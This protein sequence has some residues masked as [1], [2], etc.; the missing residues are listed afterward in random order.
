MRAKK[1]KEADLENRRKGFLLMGLTIACAFTL[2]AFE[3]ITPER[4]I[5]FI[6][7]MADTDIIEIDIIEPFRIERK[8][9]KKER[10]VN[11]DKIVVQEF[12]PEPM[13]DPLPDPDPDPMPDPILADSMLFGPEPVEIT[14]FVIVEE[15]PEFIGGEA[16]MMHW[17]ESNVHYPK[18]CIDGYVQGK[19]WV[20]FVVDT[21]G[22]IVDT[23]LLNSE[24]PALDREAKRVVEAMPR[25]KP[26]KQQGRKVKVYY[27]LP[28]HFKL[29]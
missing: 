19:V 13:P 10:I 2:T 9:Q 21:E 22:N 3:W 20:K 12:V 15:M 27:T 26:G 23:E 16:A 17:L 5:A 29:R 4:T 8:K 6:E 24:H 14:P 28:I 25:W 7:P 1:T 11:P 18:I